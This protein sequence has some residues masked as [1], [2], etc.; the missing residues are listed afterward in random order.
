MRYIL[1]L[2]C[3]EFHT[4][5]NFGYGVFSVFG[6]LWTCFGLIVL[7]EHMGWYHPVK[8][9]MGWVMVVFS[10]YTGI[11]IFPTL[12]M[13]AALFAMFTVLFIAFI[14]T[15]IGHFFEPVSRY[16]EFTAATLFMIGG[17]IAWYIMA[18]FIYLDIFKSDLV[19]LGRAPI[20][21]F[22]QRQYA[23][24]EQSVP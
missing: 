9:D 8:E 15:D 6:G 23:K 18:H 12:Y 17:F 5:N 13:D 2:G 10:V 14:F 1:A 20:L 22:R 16:F 4:G 21:F 19:P 24:A 7:S 11:W 3:Q